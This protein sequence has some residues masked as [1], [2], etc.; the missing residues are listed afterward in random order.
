MKKIYC[1]MALCSALLGWGQ[2]DND[3]LMMDKNNLCIGTMFQH[4]SWDHYWEG[5]FKRDNL[6]LGTVTHQSFGIM[7]NYGVSSKLNLL[8]GLPY[9]TAKA[10][11]GTL[12]GQKGFQDL[13]LMAKYMPI[14]TTIGNN[15]YSLYTL[16]GFSVPVSNYPADYLPLSLGLRS[17]TA[18]F[19]VMADFQRH[20][21]FSTISGAFMYRNNITIDREAYYT[22][23]YHYTNEVKMPNAIQTQLRMGYRSDY[24]I[25]ELL[26]DNMIT[27]TGFDISTNNMPFPSNTMNA[28]RVG[29]NWKYTFKKISGLSITGGSSYV[30]AGRNVGQTL[31]YNIGAFYIINFSKSIPNENKTN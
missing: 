3:A 28:S 26:W 10:S 5:T 19:R 4:E 27:Q 14:E 20:H 7:G 8:F 30:V 22:T 2:T 23:T 18:T 1:S 25:A 24:W 15:T 29:M 11:A 9:V 6:N 17:K 13:S 16:V 31:A 12:A 21:F